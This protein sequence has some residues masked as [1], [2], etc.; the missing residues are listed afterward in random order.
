MI[1][2]LDS[3]LRGDDGAKPS[4][5][6]RRRESGP[7][8]PR[9]GATLLLLCSMMSGTAFAAT[10]ETVYPIASVDISL[11]SQGALQR[12]AKYFVNYCLS[13]HSARYSRY[14]RV[15][16]DLGL[17]E[18]QVRENLIFTRQKIGGLMTTTFKDENALKWF[19]AIP[20]DLTLVARARGYDWLYTYLKSFYLD[21]TR[22]TGVN[23]ALFKNV[24]MPHALWELQGWQRPVYKTVISA[25]GSEKQVL[26]G[27][28][29]VEPGLMSEQEYDRAVRDLVTFMAYLSEPI[30]STRRAMGVW[31]LL[32]LLVL[33]GVTYA[34]KREYWKDIH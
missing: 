17:S 27:V 15:G 11:L 34:L 6:P 4:S 22:P 9:V 7:T 16:K 21:E 19:G 28:E 30:A 20:P 12:G 2:L 23:N 33:L 1:C 14:N 13:C 18:Q 31:V 5:F 24:S 32:F 25:D 3:R 29:L 8:R 10:A 26:E